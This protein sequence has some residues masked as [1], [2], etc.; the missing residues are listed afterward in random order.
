MRIKAALLCTL[1]LATAFGAVACKNPKIKGSRGRTVKANVSTFDPDADVELDLDKYGSERPDDYAV[2][3]AFHA[4]F[5]PMDECVLDAK[6]RKGMGNAAILEGDLAVAVKL[7]PAI[8]TKPAAVNTTLPRKYSKDEKLA[9][10]LR[11]A[12]GGVTFPKYDGP[13]VVV[14]LSC[15]LDAGSEYE[16]EW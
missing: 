2:Q 4:A 11:N 6:K 3:E 1:G 8:G 13:P 7:D 14:D 16:E 10:C 9:Q 15:E 12:V 5:G